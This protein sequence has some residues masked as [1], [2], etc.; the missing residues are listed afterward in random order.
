MYQRILIAIDYEDDGEG[1]RALE[2]GVRLLS[3]GGEL[4]LA[5]IYDPGG[6][7]FFP[8]VGT[9][10]PADRENEV[11]ERLSLLARKYLPMQYSAKLHIIAGSPGEKLV[12]LAANIGADLII[13][14]SKGAGSRWQLRRA[15]KEYVV[16]NACCATLILPQELDDTDTGSD[17]DSDE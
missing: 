7:G 6:T 17:P 15:T 3:E 9:E 1:K 13:L 8:H 5:T 2:E 14:V 10:T 12:A 4:H 11:R 16:V